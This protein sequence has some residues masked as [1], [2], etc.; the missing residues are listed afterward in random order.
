M[1]IFVP[2]VSLCVHVS[3][4]LSIHLGVFSC[5]YKYAYIYI[6]DRIC[7]NPACRE[8]AQVAQRA[9]LVPR[10][11]NCQSPV[12][13]IFMSKNHSTNYCR[14]LRRVNISYQ[15]EISL[16]LQAPRSTQSVHLPYTEPVA[17]GVNWNSRSRAILDTA[18]FVESLNVDSPF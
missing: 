18:R 7:E 12:F 2:C 9:F 8:N 15:G 11:E 10:V 5:M 17:K 6:C 16:Y 3:L 13:V 14:S 4:Y 1:C